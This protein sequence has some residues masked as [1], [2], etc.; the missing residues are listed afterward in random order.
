MDLKT[1]YSY[2]VILFLHHVDTRLASLAHD[3]IS[4]ILQEHID[5]VNSF[6]NSTVFSYTSWKGIVHLSAPNVDWEIYKNM[7]E[8]KW[9]YRSD[10]GQQE[11]I[12]VFTNILCEE[13][14]LNDIKFFS[15]L[16]PQD[17]FLGDFMKFIYYAFC[18]KDYKQAILHITSLIQTYPNISTFY[19]L[20]VR[21]VFRQLY[22]YISPQR[23]NK[24]VLSQSWQ[25]E[26]KDYAEY[27]KCMKD[28]DCAEKYN[29]SNPVIQLFRARILLHFNDVKGAEML[30]ERDI[31]NRYKKHIN[32]W[33]LI[34]YARIDDFIKVQH[35]LG[36]SS[37][38]NDYSYVIGKAVEI[39]M[40]KKT[41]DFSGFFEM[42]Q[43]FHLTLVT[44]QGV[45]KYNK[46]HG[47]ELKNEE[48]YKIS[49]NWRKILIPCILSA[50]IIRIKKLLLSNQ[51][52]KAYIY[53]FESIS[54]DF[55]EYWDINQKKFCIFSPE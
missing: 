22:M 10:T 9:F 39:Y 31:Y 17:R 8:S 5:A 19:L 13:Y 51:V 46:D 4:E 16:F 15:E 7:Y 11:I 38:S 30:M 14:S 52:R 33:L 25:Q 2:F 12:K 37:K 53:L 28:L 1:Q 47:M 24:L 29:P 32:H 43:A 45:L 35:Y 34:F 27:K 50:D 54:S 41:D 36:L 40:Y 48:K 42:I 20:R 26:I 55:L 18:E 44:E 21:M 23:F 3:D 49:L 6:Y